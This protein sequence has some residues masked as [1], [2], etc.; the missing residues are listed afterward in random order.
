M[1]KKIIEF[2]NSKN[3]RE[4]IMMAGV[5]WILA[6]I[7][8]SLISRASSENATQIENLQT[9][10]NLAKT[11]ISQSEKIKATLAKVKKSFDPKKTV[12]S[13]N[14]QL[15]VEKCA[16]QAGLAYTLSSPSTK[17]S[18]DFK[19]HTITL[20]CRAANL[21]AL[22]KFEELLQTYEPY[23]SVEKISLDA[24]AKDL[25]AKYSIISVEL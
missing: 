3:T 13:T 22:A 2:Y 21:P 4:K 25:G 9:K 20:A 24:N 11:V 18:K 23:L 14:L 8:L 5:L 7:W 15:L 17:D 12:D 19:I 1:L 16:S 6:F 10:I